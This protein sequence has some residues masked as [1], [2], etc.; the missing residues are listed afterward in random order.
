[1][2]RKQRWNQKQQSKSIRATHNII[3]AEPR[4]VIMS[5]IWMSIASCWSNH[6]QGYCCIERPQI[7][8]WLRP[9]VEHWFNEYK[10]RRRHRHRVCLSFWVTLVSGGWPPPG[11]PPVT[12]TREMLLL[13]L[14]I[15]LNPSP[16]WTPKAENKEANYFRQHTFSHSRLC[17]K[18][19]GP[20]LN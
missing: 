17:K 6:A 9:S 16:H 2:N 19:I 3:W 14:Y 20:I 18:N 4:V 13:E 5:A 8:K 11:S 1:M 15:V 10:H 7:T 12:C